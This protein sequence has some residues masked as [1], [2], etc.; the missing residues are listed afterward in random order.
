[1][2]SSDTL[3]DIL[4]RLRAPKHEHDDL[5]KLLSQGLQALGLPLPTLQTSPISHHDVADLQETIRY[6]P[7]FQLVLVENILPHWVDL[8]RDSGHMDLVTSYFLPIMKKA[9][10]TSKVQN[11]LMEC[12][13]SAHVNLLIPPISQFSIDL[14]NRIHTSYPPDNVFNYIIHRKGNIISNYP[15]ERWG[16]Y[17]DSLLQTSGKVMNAAGENKMVVPDRL[18]SS[19][20]LGAA[21]LALKRLIVGNFNAEDENERD[22]ATQLLG[23][24]I[25]LGAF[26]SSRPVLQSNPSFWE[27]TLPDIRQNIILRSKH[28]ESLSQPTKGKSSGNKVT[29]SYSDAFVPILMTLP[30]TQQIGVFHSLLSHL[31]LKSN[32]DGVRIGVD[33]SYRRMIKREALVLQETIGSFHIDPSDNEKGEESIWIIVSS[34]LE[35]VL[36]ESV[37]RT[38]ICWAAI[39]ISPYDNLRQMLNRA[40]ELWSDESHIKHSSLHKHHVTTCL[41]LLTVAELSSNKTVEPK[42]VNQIRTL[43]RNALFISAVG[44]YIAHPDPSIRRCGM[45]TAEV[46]AQLSGGKLTFPGWEGNGD[47]REWAREM[48]EVMKGLDSDSDIVEGLVQVDEISSRGDEREQQESPFQGLLEERPA[49]Q[50]ARAITIQDGEDSDDSLEGYESATSSSSSVTSFSP[51]RAIEKEVGTEIKQKP[52]KSSEFRPTVEEINDDPSLLIPTKNRVR[53]PVYLLDLG[54]LFKVTKEGNEQYESI[55]MGLET[56]TELIRRKA[57]WGLELE[58][59]AVDLTCSLLSLQNNYDIEDFDRLVLEAVTALVACCP[60]KVAP[61]IIEHFFTPSYSTMHRFTML[62]ALALGARELAG[63]PTPQIP[64]QQANFPSRLLPPAVHRKYIT[65]EDLSDAGAQ[66]RGLLED[67][68]SAAI[69]RGREE[70]EK[71]VP[72]IVRER[73]LT[74]NPRAGATRSIVE[75]DDVRIKSLDALIK[76][77]PIM[78]NKIAAEFFIIPLTSKFWGYLQDALGRE[79]RA[80]RFGTTGGYRATGTAMILSPLVLSHLVNTIAILTHASRHSSSFLSLIAPATLEIAVT[81]GTRRLDTELGD[82]DPTSPDKESRRAASVL[83]ACL[84]L[85]IVVL[86]SCIELDG[87]KVLALENSSL[88]SGVA[89]WAQKVF[90]LLESGIRFEGV[91]GKEEMRL[92]K[93]SA[94]LVLKVEEVTG[95][96]KQI[97]LLPY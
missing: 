90:E 76:K 60:R 50:K 94:G 84:E 34:V 19:G 79:E 17:V 31:D 6:I 92:K 95:R 68:S 38:V 91:G 49:V 56:A 57:G 18:H 41:L 25:T 62:N 81:L 35:R 86:D 58:E 16:D 1:M 15:L 46:V 36:S 53:K 32:E 43:A 23:R 7:K 20:V 89:M 64:K 67:V 2:A 27:M 11:I 42:G 44:S 48:R 74:V 26:P 3:Q 21:C 59:N 24:L 55:R 82:E 63:L 85:A 22:A 40:V 12:V 28:S 88:I 47:G 87:G 70:A 66:I 69:N 83:S 5:V 29:R 33:P 93:A 73:K 13:I 71:K 30:I 72:E 10:T 96:W 39:S 54:R 61:T 14:L 52:S 97:M 75:V 9:P 80:S 4:T 78:Y 45:L 77:T 51:S 37:M 65:Q 8:L